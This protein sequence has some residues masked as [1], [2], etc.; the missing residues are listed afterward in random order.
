MIQR[1]WCISPT[2]TTQ[3]PVAMHKCTTIW[4]AK[5]NTTHMITTRYTPHGTTYH[6]KPTTSIQQQAS[7]SH[8]HSM[9]MKT[10]AVLHHIT[11]PYQ[12]TRTP[13]A[14]MPWWRRIAYDDITARWSHQD[15]DYT[16]MIDTR[17]YMMITQRWS[18]T[19]R[20]MR[21]ITMHNYE[22]W[23]RNMTMMDRVWHANSE[24][25]RHGWRVG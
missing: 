8:D 4:R 21:M 14:T 22:V 13:L 23:L 24:V 18:I 9:T 12:H 7:Q 6:R 5:S 15:D 19:W 10:W 25:A 16:K 2:T 17:W 1:R 3:T 11:S 20:V